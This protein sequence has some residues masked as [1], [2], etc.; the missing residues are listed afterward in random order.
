MC[1][2][3]PSFLSLPPPPPPPSP[4]PECVVGDP[5][6]LSAAPGSPGSCSEKCRECAGPGTV[7]ESREEPGEETVYQSNKV[8]V[9]NKFTIS[10]YYDHF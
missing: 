4:Q 9:D 2:I 7:V 3:S 10:R 6:H 8:C 1:E 5:S